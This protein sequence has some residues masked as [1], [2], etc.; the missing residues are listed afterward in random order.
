MPNLGPSWSNDGDE[1]ARLASSV[2]QATFALT[3]KCVHVDHRKRLLNEAIW[4]VTERGSVSRKYLLRYRTNGALAIQASMT[5]SAAAKLLHH[6]HV[7]PRKGL[8]QQLLQ[9][10]ADVAALLAGAVACVVTR[11]EHKLLSAHEDKVGWARYVA[12][13]LTVVDLASN[14]PLDLAGQSP[15]VS[16]SFAAAGDV[17]G[18]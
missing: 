4:F 3:D 6:E 1:A 16:A 11:D 2:A 12:A 18:K 14:Q 13:G 10:G 5:P 8:V 7:Q 17:V 15:V 9:P